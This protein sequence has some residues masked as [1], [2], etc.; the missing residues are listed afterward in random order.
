[1]IQARLD[2]HMRQVP[3]V[4]KIG[5][6]FGMGS[7]DDCSF[8]IDAR[9]Q[10]LRFLL[11]DQTIKLIGKTFYNEQFSY[12]MKD[13]DKREFLRNIAMMSLTIIIPRNVIAWCT[14]A[15]EIP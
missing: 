10:G 9:S 15:T 6:E 3:P 14:D 8:G 13:P 7:P 4:E 12:V 5:A 11:P 2:Q 1:M